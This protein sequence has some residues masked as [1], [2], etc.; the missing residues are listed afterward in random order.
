ME[1]APFWLTNHAN[2][3][4]D[5]MYKNKCPILYNFSVSVA[6][7][8]TDTSS[9]LAGGVRARLFQ[10][11]NKA[12]LVELDTLKKKLEDEL[13]DLDPDNPDFSK[14]EELQKSYSELIEKPLWTIDFAAAIGGGSST[15][16]F[17]DLALNRWSAWLYF[18]LETKRK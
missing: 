1:F 14:I 10:S 8:K 18:K 6:T 2:L 4:A 9:Y 7:I 17:N 12:I 5:K 13:A 15:N 11:Y 16:S 3:T